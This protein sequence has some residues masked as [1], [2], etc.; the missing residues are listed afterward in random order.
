MANKN[1]I[2]GTEFIGSV[3][4]DARFMCRSDLPLRT[5]LH[6]RLPS[7]HTTK[8]LNVRNLLCILPKEFIWGYRFK[9][10]VFISG[11]DNHVHFVLLKQKREKTV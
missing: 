4:W 2:A 7:D 3:G 6:Q 9:K 10:L 1:N 5:L 11:I 8:Y